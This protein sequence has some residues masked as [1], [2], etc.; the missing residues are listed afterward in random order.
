MNL[1]SSIPRITIALLLAAAGATVFFLATN[2]KAAAAVEGRTHSEPAPGWELSNLEG[3][4]VKFSDFAG[5]VVVL[6]F[7]ATWCP[8]CR[9]EIPGFTELQNKYGKQGLAIV[10]ISLDQGGAQG[11]KKFAQKEG[12]NY[13]ILIGTQDVVRAF[14]GVAAIPTTFII[15][16]KGRVIA[17]HEGFTDKDEFDRE[18]KPLL[19]P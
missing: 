3:Q 18:I 11:V 16:Q 1:S 10:G 9:A 6:D 12:V 7:W 15:D 17:R 19:K 2:P 8:P 13:P 4:K 5:K 14:G